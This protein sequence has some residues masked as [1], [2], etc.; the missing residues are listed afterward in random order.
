MGLKV[1]LSVSSKTR[2]RSTLI[3]LSTRANDI[4][5]GSSSTHLNYSTSIAYT[6]DIKSLEIINIV[7]NNVIQQITLTNN[8]KLILFK[9]LIKLIDR[10]C[11]TD[12]ETT[13]KKTF[14]QITKE[15]NFEILI[16]SYKCNLIQ[17]DPRQLINLLH[18]SSIRPLIEALVNSNEINNPYLIETLD[19]YLSL[20]I[21]EANQAKQLHE[22]V[23]MAKGCRN[24]LPLIMKQLEH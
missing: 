6:D 4:R 21:I 19:T 22:F 20:N 11:P 17:C 18:D 1:E 2:I 23:E 24:Y 14:G 5:L 7:V 10:F 16:L 3:Y 8:G 15:L 13:S 9:K 12:T